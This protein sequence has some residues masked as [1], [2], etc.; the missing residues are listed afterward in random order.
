MIVHLQIFRIFTLILNNAS[1]I[2]IA[3]KYPSIREL[4][5]QIMGLN[6]GEYDSL[7]RSFSSL[8]LILFT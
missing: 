3:I 6:Q 5:N 8:L 1:F 4:K 7:F 2:K